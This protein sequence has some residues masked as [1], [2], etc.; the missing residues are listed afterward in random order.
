MHLKCVL[1]AGFI[2]YPES[3]R[4]TGSPAFHVVSG[5]CVV[6]LAVARPDYAYPCTACRLSSV[7]S[8]SFGY[9][10][11]SSWCGRLYPR[12]DSV[13]AGQVVFVSGDTRNKDR[14][15]VTMPAY[16]TPDPTQP[17]SD[18]IPLCPSSPGSGLCNV[19]SS[20]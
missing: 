11:Y 13:Q 8:V 5:V 17:Q 20:L 2:R 3:D 9:L 10:R 15:F 1:S 16:R 18:V 19:N 12:D 4:V 6:S 7:S 14:F